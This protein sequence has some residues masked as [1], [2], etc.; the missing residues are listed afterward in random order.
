MRRTRAFWHYPPGTMVPPASGELLEWLGRAPNA[1]PGLAYRLV[2]ALGRRRLGVTLEGELPPGPVLLVGGPHRR[3]RD[4]F[5]LAFALPAS[6]R[7]WGLGLGPGFLESRLHEMVIRRVGGVLPFWRGHGGI[8]PILEAARAV[9]T[10]GSPFAIMPEGGIGGPPDRLAEFRPGAAILAA[11]L[12]IPVVPFALVDGERPR[13]ILLPARPVALPAG[14][15]PGTRAEVRWAR[16]A[17][18]AL[19]T[20]IETVWLAAREPALVEATATT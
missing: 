12:A 19:A 1:K 6:P 4:P 5:V 13:I 17:I 3:M 10:A 8:E 7:V 9:V 16:E 11:R 2:H 18:E 15:D 14:V 20:E